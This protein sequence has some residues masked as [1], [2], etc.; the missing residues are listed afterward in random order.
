MASQDEIRTERIRKLELLKEKGID[1]Y[2]AESLRT[3]TITDFLANFQTLESAQFES[4]LA[5]RIMSFRKHG[6]LSFLDINDGTASIQV[7]CKLDAMGSL[8]EDLQTLV[9]QGDFVEITGPA[10]ITAKGQQ[11]IFCNNWRMISKSIRALPD[12]WY[13]LKDEDERL[14]MR[15]VDMILT[16][17]LQ[18]MARKRSLFWNTI[19]TYLLEKNFIEVETPV[20][21]NT[22]GGAEARPFITH[23]NALDIDVFLRISAGELWQKKLLVGGLPRTFEIGR[24]F[25][26]E[27]ISPEHLQDYTQLE[28]YMAYSDYVEGM[29]MTK[30]LYQLIGEKVFGTTKFTIKGFNIDLADEW[31]IYD[32][33]HI[34]NT[35]YNIDILSVS[36][37][38]LASV[39]TLADIAYDKNTLTVERGV[40]LLW[41]KI[42]KTL[43][44]PGFLINVPVFMEPLAKRSR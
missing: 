37:D 12:S 40:D 14:R 6:A 39:L 33:T 26:N 16:P 5:G 21:E 18:D 15:Y 9:D 2:P 31:E 22:T 36:T 24:I 17:A 28:Y 23:H 42:R 38:Q 32:Y 25:R 10:Y 1:P 41:K 29:A 3:S 13:G 30:E 19:R 43:A 4:I 35:T 20:L 7:F 8:Y 27:G 34:L 44:G 11:S